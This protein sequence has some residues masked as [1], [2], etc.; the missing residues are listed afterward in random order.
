MTI[1]PDSHI[2]VV[3]NPHARRNAPRLL[4]DLQAASPQS[5]TWDVIETRADQFRF[6]ELE[7]RARGAACVV[8]VG[9]DGTVTDALTGIGDAHIPVAIVAGG[10]TN[11]IAQELGMP[12]DAA[13]VSQLI[14]GTH[15]V[16]TMDAAMCNERLFLHMA[17]AGFDSRIFDQTN[18]ELK[19]RVGWFAYLPSAASSIRLPPARFH[20]ETETATFEL[21]S[22]MVLV[23]N[24]AGVIRPSLYVFPGISSTDGWLDL[25]AVTA[26]RA[27][28]IASVLA[29]FAS[30]SMD[31]SPHILHARAKTIRISADPPMPVQVD[32]DVVGSTDVTIKVMPGRAQMIVP[33]RGTESATEA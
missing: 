3:A 7:V 32:G 29:R 5:V 22:P 25:I 31:R 18:P 2:L 9:G 16:R 12:N 13:G 20:V 21:T 27:A 10:S 14:F 8:T 33:Q 19:R 4:A 1:A 26:T 17:G 28:H 30:R 11:V 15:A 24:G 6:G 23:A